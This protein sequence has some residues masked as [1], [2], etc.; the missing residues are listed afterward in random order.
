MFM[1]HYNIFTTSV[2]CYHILRTQIESSTS[3]LT[4]KSLSITRWLANYESI[5]SL[6]RSVPE[7]RNTF[8]VI[9][10]CLDDKDC[11][12]TVDKLTLEDKKTR[13]QVNVL[14]TTSCNE[15]PFFLFSRPSTYKNR[16]YHLNLLCC[17][18]FSIW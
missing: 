3:A 17:C 18:T 15:S 13:Q 14:M 10:D 16:F 8:S 6:N 11:S 2:K 5:N 12:D 9:I 4:V 1:P 7:I